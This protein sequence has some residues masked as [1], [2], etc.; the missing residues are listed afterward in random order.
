MHSLW[1]IFLDYCY[2]LVILIRFQA[3]NYTNKE[4]KIIHLNY[5]FLWY[6]GIGDKKNV[7]FEYLNKS[8]TTTHSRVVIHIKLKIDPPPKIKKLMFKGININFKIIWSIIIVVTY[9]KIKTFFYKLSTCTDIKT[10]VPH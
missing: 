5:W 2:W 6:L 1:K 8:F 7:S 3:F 9:D 10:R 4:T